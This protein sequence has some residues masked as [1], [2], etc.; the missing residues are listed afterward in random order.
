[1][2]EKQGKTVGR[3]G[4]CCLQGRSGGWILQLHTGRN[5]GYHARILFSYLG[6]IPCIWSRYARERGHI[7]FQKS[8]VC[9]DKAR[10]DQNMGMG[11]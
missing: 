7:S 3:H 11:G 2:L 9:M 10:V 6:M 1:M 8:V 5:R 4:P